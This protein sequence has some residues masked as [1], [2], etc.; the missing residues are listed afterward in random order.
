[1]SDTIFVLGV[2]VLCIP[3]PLIIIFHYVTR[4]KKSR[5]LT[6]NDENM[7]EELWAQA[8]RMEDRVVTLETILDDSD[9]DWRRK[10]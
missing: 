5:E 6:G 10:T 3:V 9:P 2:L 8:K 4:W 1:M 7:L